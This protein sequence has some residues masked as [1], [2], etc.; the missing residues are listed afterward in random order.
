MT[1]AEFKKQAYGI[2][3]FIIF[4]MGT[5][6]KATINF[7]NYIITE[8]NFEMRRILRRLFFRSTH[9]HI[10]TRTGKKSNVFFRLKADADKKTLKFY[11]SYFLGG[12]RLA[13]AEK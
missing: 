10:I 4:C 6:H 1:V 3:R 7:D 11:F 12:R 2:D 13:K 8:F 9:K 5:Y